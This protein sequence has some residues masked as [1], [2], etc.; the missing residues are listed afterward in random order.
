MIEKKPKI[1]LSPNRH[2]AYDVGAWHHI[3]VFAGLIGRREVLSMFESL[4]DRI[5]QDEMQET[6]QK[7]RILKWL[8][9]GVVSVVLF[10]GLYMGVKLLE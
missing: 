7:E 3:R 2:R 6:T 10:T 5:K 8:V 1:T 9:V 4:D